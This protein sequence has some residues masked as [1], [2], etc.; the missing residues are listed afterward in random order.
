MTDVLG[1]TMP[2]GKKARGRQNRS[3]KEANLTAK[4]RSQW[5]PTILRN[6][7]GVNDTC[8]HTLAVLPR[9][10]QV[11]PAI[12]FMNCLAGE[13]FFEKATRFTGTTDLCFQ[14]LMRF[15]EIREEES[16]RSLAMDLLLRFVRNVLVHDFEVA[17]ESWFRQRNR[18]EVAICTMIHQLELSGTYSDL[19]VVRR[20]SSKT[21]N[22]LIG[23]NRRDV[24]KF[25]AKRLPSTRLKELHR[26][27][28]MKVG[29]VGRCFHC[30]EQ[31]PR[32][33]LHVCT[34]CNFREYCSRECQRTDWSDHKE[35]CGYPEVTRRDLPADYVLEI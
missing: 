1:E 18:N 14:S 29:K 7:N 12:S 31:F 25:V 10:P 27:T 32:S 24:V 5:E 3:K 15:P 13:G 21:G 22:K 19:F 2:S 35:G 6:N 33:Q 17:G 4:Q 30:R 9:I 11:G 28:R 16:E 20:R 26:A 8:E 23:G 34:G